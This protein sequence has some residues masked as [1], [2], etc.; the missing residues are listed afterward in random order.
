MAPR[1]A[2]ADAWPSFRGGPTLEGRRPGKVADAPK[3][4]WTFESKAQIESTAAIVGDRLWVGTDSGL[5]CLKLETPKAEGKATGAIDV[6][7]LDERNLQ[8]LRSLATG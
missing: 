4:L 2:E 6:D 3:L 5:L 1:A 8:T 7:P